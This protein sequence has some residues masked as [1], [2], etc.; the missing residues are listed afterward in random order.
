MDVDTVQVSSQ[1]HLLMIGAVI[2]HIAQPCF[3]IMHAFVHGH[4]GEPQGFSGRFKYFNQSRSRKFRCSIVITSLYCCL[5]S[6]SFI[7]HSKFK[8]A[9]SPFAV[10]LVDTAYTQI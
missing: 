2:V 1:F 6:K 3:D 8:T 7:G 4:T 5:F 9:T 10:I